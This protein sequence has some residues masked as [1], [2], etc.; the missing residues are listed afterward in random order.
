M[1][2]PTKKKL[3]KQFPLIKFSVYL[4][5]C[6]LSESTIAIY[7]AELRKGLAAGLPI[8]PCEDFEAKVR[9]HSDLLDWVHNKW[10]VSAW[11]RF[12]QYLAAQA[13]PIELPQ[14]FTDKRVT[15]NSKLIRA[16]KEKRKEAE[17]EMKEEEE[18]EADTGTA[19][20]AA[21]LEAVRVILAKTTLT[22]NE[23]VTLRWGTL[24]NEF[25]GWK[26]FS[27]GGVDVYYTVVVPA[28]DILHDWAAP[29]R[30]GHPLIP[31]RPGS[32]VSLSAP[33]LL[34]YLK[35][36]QDEAMRIEI[37]QKVAAWV[38][39]SLKQGVNQ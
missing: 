18:K 5:R 15:E 26:I 22:H 13:P 2:I 9:A 37:E 3:N 6:K 1:P 19:P 23:L 7:L 36:H 29:K 16:E 4:R 25:T 20:P 27:A 39:A 24:R 33:A 32:E 10:F 14:I 30:A 11:N 34:R 28:T 8:S 35:R 12:T 31:V 21:V 17:A 38:S